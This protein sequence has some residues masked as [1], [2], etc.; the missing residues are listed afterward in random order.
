MWGH[1]FNHICGNRNHEGIF[2]KKGSH[3]FGDSHSSLLQVLGFNT[4]A[5]GG[6][7]MLTY[8]NA[9]M[10][11]NMWKDVSGLLN[12]GAIQPNDI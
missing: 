9:N 6:N 11:G 2:F 8:G 3:G 12:G 5:Y 4:D 10:L 1:A 7:I